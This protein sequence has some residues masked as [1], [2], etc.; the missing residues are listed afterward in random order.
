MML[1]EAMGDE[2]QQQQTFALNTAASLGYIDVALAVAC[3]YPELNRSR[4]LSMAAIHADV[5]TLRG[6][7]E[8]PPRPN[9]PINIDDAMR[10]ACAGAHS[11]VLNT[12]LDVSSEITTFDKNVLVRVACA[13]GFAHGVRRLM[14]C[15]ADVWSVD[16]SRMSCMH[17]AVQAGRRSQ[18]E[19]ERQVCA[20][21]TVALLL[22]T[23]AAI[24]RPNASKLKHTL[25][26]RRN[27]EAQTPLQ[28]AIALQRRRVA[29]LLLKHGA[30]ITRQD[31][32]I[33]LRFVNGSSKQSLF[34]LSLL[35]EC[36][37]A[38]DV[39]QLRQLTPSVRT[40]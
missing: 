2:A 26:V 13:S 11:D 16:A 23:R 10:A 40:V 18:P 27:A 31:L 5:F 1:L 8:E 14:E 24:H 7:L 20:A 6:L 38:P 19:A 28:L 22:E 12:L 30:Q 25:L 21:T 29:I 36:G 32:A 34:F 17:L 35:M 37:A 15:G 33:A 4:A 3:R 39:F 9:T